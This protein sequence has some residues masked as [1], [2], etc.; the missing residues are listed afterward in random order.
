MNEELPKLMADAQAIADDAQKTFGH[1][2]GE[3]LNWK[4]NADQWSVAQCFAHLIA[5]NSV[6]FPV[7]ERIVRGG[8]RPS[9]KERLPLLPRFFGSMVLK[10]VEPQGARKFKAATRFQPSNS[11]IAG[12]IISKFRTHQKDVIEHMR[13][14][15]QVDLR[16]VIITSPVASMVTYSLLDA[17]RIVVAHERRH[18]AQ[19]RRVME[20]RGFP[21]GATSAVKSG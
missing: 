10:A 19:A 13:M 17:Y 4:A 3:Q 18:I 15:E 12:D 5:I 2:S 7:I 1:V 16:R 11:T 6:Y 21:G 20:T 9:W 8:Y 14:S